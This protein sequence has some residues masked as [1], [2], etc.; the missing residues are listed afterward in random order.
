MKLMRKKDQLLIYAPNLAT[1]KYINQILTNLKGEE[2]DNTIKARNFIARYRSDRQKITK[3][4]QF[5]ND[6]FD[7][8]NLVFI[9]IYF[10]LANIIFSS[11]SGLLRLNYMLKRRRSLN[12]FMEMK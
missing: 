3:E 9:S 4:T 7:E 8:I 5:L 2:V 12:K 10:R 11:T 6:K 1:P